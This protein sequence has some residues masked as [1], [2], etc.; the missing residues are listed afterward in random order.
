MVLG[1]WIFLPLAYFLG[2]SFTIVQAGIV[3]ISLELGFILI[4]LGRIMVKV[5]P[6]VTED[7]DTE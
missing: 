3:L 5:N 7:Q 1:I 4:G 6:L 2:A